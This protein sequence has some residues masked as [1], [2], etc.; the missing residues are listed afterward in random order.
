VGLIGAGVFFG[1]KAKS[2]KD[3]LA[4]L[5]SGGKWDQVSTTTARPPIAT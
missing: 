3:D 4:A 2:A 1:L 5:E